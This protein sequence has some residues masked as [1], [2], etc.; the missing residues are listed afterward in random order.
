MIS[1]KEDVG[2]AEKPTKPKEV[3]RFSASK[4]ALEL[5]GKA[6]AEA[7]YRRG[8]L[9]QALRSFRLSASKEADLESK[10]WIALQ[11]GNC[12]REMGE[13][14]EALAAYEK[15]A[16]EFDE[17]IWGKYAKWAAEDVRWRRTWEQKGPLLELDDLL[18]DTR[19]KDR[20]SA[21]NENT[22]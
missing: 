5:G 19:Q 14:N 2:G 17:T 21:Q 16:R 12:H 20:A 6:L 11:I 8:H 18:P 13:L 7:L 15:T 22:R 4:N 10:A 1:P 9:A 3:A